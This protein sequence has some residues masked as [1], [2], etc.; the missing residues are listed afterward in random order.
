M[1]ESRPDVPV[2]RAVVLA[3]GASA[4]LGRPKQLLPV[5][6][7]PLLE[8]TLSSVASSAVTGITVV[9]GYAAVTIQ[10]A[11]DFSRY[12]ARVVVNAR[13]AEGQSTSMRAGLDALST[14]VD[15]ALFVLGDQPLTGSG[16]YDAILAAYRHARD[17]IV[18]PVYAGAPG[19]PVLIPRRYWP[20]L[21]RVRGDRG[22]R[23]VVA[24]HRAE[25]VTVEVSGTDAGTNFD[26][27][28]EEDYQRLLALLA[29]ATA[30]CVDR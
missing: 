15:A 25:L 13:Y 4:R 3:A 29:G 24:A 16:V 12:R 30:R 26:V 5:R 2:V 19:N 14:E 28:L 7:K 17:A 27:D 21:R 11:I 6:G 20:E 18:V 22:A 23:D 10:E 9:L 1:T 8:H